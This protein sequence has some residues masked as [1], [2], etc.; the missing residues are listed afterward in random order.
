LI[1]SRLLAS[2]AFVVAGLLGRALVDRLLAARGGAVAVAGWA[3]LSSMAEVVSGV[4]LAG[5]GT[6]LTVLSAAGLGRDERTWLKPALFISLVLSS[7]VAIL[8]L[9]LLPRL[10]TPLLPGAGYLLPLALLAGGLAVAPGLLVALLLGIGRPGRATAVIALGFVPPIL[11]L[12]WGPSA[13]SLLDLLIGQG[14]FGLAVA[15]GLAVFLR[16]QPPISRPGLKTLLS[17]LPAGLAIGILSPAATAWARAEIA[18]SLSWH[19]AGQVQALWRTSE[20]ITA[21][22]A[23]LLN[24][25]FLPR[26]SAAA[27]PPAFLAELKQAVIATALPAALL[28]A[29]LWVFLPEALA[30]LYRNAVSVRREDAVFFLLGDW[31]RIMSW[32]A[33]IGLFARRSAW[34]ISL[35]EFLSLPLFALLLTLF[36]GHFGLREVGMM[37]LAAYAAYAA[38][39]A[40]LLRRSLGRPQLP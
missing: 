24:A 7:G 26:L 27:D 21:I 35:G 29:L 16:G 1:A 3:Q 22:M 23:G 9:A 6:A 31:V 30:L 34:A 11:C 18:G 14:L 19:G 8:L 36:S 32:V 33:L 28:L 10:P 5:I 25:H 15:I 17:F 12:L 37:W 2:F 20:W 13:S 40:V 4:S 39:N 38:F